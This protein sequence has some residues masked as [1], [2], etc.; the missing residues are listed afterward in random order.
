MSKLIALF[1]RNISPNPEKRENISN[2]KLCYERLYY[3]FKDWSFVDEI[4]IHKIDKLREMLLHHSTFKTTN[5]K[6]RR[7]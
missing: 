2:T 5:P 6:G 1:T 4:P 3:D 7:L